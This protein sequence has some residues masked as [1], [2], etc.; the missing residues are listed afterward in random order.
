MNPEVK[1]L[2]C[3][4][5]ES[6]DYP[7][8]EGFLRV[9]ENHDEEDD[10]PVPGYCCLGVLC[11]L[12][13][14]AG[15]IPPGA[16]E[17][18]EGGRL[19]RVTYGKP[20]GDQSDYRLPAAVVRWAGLGHVPNSKSPAIPDRNGDMNA[21]ANMNDSDYKFPEIARLIREAL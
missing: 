5:L 11:E 4:A 20:R 21:L 17:L 8:T 7:Q 6:G 12:A 19:T 3:T 15:V 1:E 16:E 13:V 9:T 2:W 10:A 14:Q 18:G